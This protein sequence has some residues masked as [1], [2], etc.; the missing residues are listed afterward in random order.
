MSAYPIEKIIKFADSLKIDII[1]IDVDIPIFNK[2]RI[3][4]HPGIYILTDHLGKRYIGASENI[5]NRQKYHHIKN[6]DT[7]DVFLTEDVLWALHLERYLIH[8]LNP[9]LN[10]GCGI[11]RHIPTKRMVLPRNIY[12][13]LENKQ[14]ELH[15]KYGKMIQISDIANAAILRGIDSIE[16]IRGFSKE[17]LDKLI[18]NPTYYS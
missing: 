5:F 18:Y 1:Y 11:S 15:T 16:K 4:D 2:K 6:V 12:A 13:I 17:T 7:I 14:I 9:E 10:Y 8:E 3:P